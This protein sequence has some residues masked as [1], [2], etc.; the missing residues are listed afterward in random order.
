[1]NIA[2]HLRLVLGPAIDAA[3]AALRDL[4]DEDVPGRLRAISKRGD[5]TLPVPLV[6]TLLRRIDEDDWFRDKVIESFDRL[7]TKDPVS[8]AYLNR[9]PVW[10][11]AV[12]ESVATQAAAGDED[13]VRQLQAKLEEARTR[14]RSERAKIKSL[15]RQAADAG[16]D[17]QAV[18]AERLDPLKAAV[19]EARSACDRAESRAVGLRAD[20]E[21]AHEEQREAERLA[22]VYSEQIRSA[23]REI[24]GLR[25]SVEAGASES[26]PRDPFE[27]A[28]W[29]DRATATLNPF[30]DADTALSN[31][32]GTEGDREPAVPA[33]VA[34][35]SAASIEALAG[36]DGV[37]ILIDGHNVL[38]V[39]DASTMATGRAR[40][41]LV[42][43]LGKLDRHLGEVTIEVVFDSDLVDGRPIT[44]TESGVVVRFA[45]AD[46]IADDVL[47]DLAAEHGSTAIVISDDREVRDRSARHGATVLWAKALAAWL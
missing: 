16:K 9:E 18:V 41:E 12:A 45:D 26:I 8:A 38:G 37:T 4:D 22:A 29:L 25:R 23:K 6:K 17:A 13:R 15:K 30:R 28:R 2:K 27:I 36:L 42:T 11:I 39:L 1:M 24:A 14:S 21:E 44:V 35:D 10:W 46:V 33:G 40:R 43:G 20:V 5:G 19:A 47:V 32:E 3:R 34:P 7:G 31:V